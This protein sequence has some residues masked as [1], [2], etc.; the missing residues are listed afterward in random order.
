MAIPIV[1]DMRVIV[2][3]MDQG[4]GTDL[5]AL[6]LCKGIGVDVIVIDD[7]EYTPPDQPADWR[8]AMERMVKGV[9]RIV[10]HTASP[11]LISKRKARRLRG[12]ARA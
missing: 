8:R 7:V 2:M 1:T 4:I 3:G 10:S 5:T 12:K 6:A 9:P 11:T